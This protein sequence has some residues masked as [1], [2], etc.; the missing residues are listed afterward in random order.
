MLQV[1]LTRW[2]IMWNGHTRERLDSGYRTTSRVE[3]GLSSVHYHRKATGEG[4]KR[5]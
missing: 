4:R 5:P 1:L 3:L 2:Y